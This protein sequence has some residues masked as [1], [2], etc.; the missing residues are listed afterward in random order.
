MKNLCFAG[1]GMKG[2]AYIGV[3][4]YLLEHGLFSTLKNVIGTSQNMQ[5]IG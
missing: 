2:V 3:Y 4:K 5:W 1:G